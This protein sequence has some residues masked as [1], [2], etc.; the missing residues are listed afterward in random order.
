MLPIGEVYSKLAFCWKRK[1]LIYLGECC[2]EL[3][4]NNHII[5]GALVYIFRA[6]EWSICTGSSAECAGE[7][8]SGITAATIEAGGD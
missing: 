6:T 2:T 5:C 1:S 7:S 4:E 3:D 8:S